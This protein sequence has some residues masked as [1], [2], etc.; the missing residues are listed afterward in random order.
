MNGFCKDRHFERLAGFVDV[1]QITAFE[2]GH[3]LKMS[4]NLLSDP[5]PLAVPVC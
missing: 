1:S 4:M 5:L 2:R 3:D